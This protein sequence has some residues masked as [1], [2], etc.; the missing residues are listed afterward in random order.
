[1][2]MTR[3][4]IR[5]FNRWLVCGL[6]LFLISLCQGKSHQQLHHPYSD[7]KK[8]QAFISSMSGRFGYTAESLDRIFAQVYRNDNILKKISRPAEK[9]TPWYRYR[10]IFLDTGRIQNGVAFYRAHQRILQQAYERY[11]VPPLIIVAIIGVESRYGRIMGSDK[12]IEALSTMAFDYPQRERFFTEE[13]RAFLQMTAKAQLE[14]LEL[15]G[16]YAGAMGMAQFMPSSY[17]RYAVDGDGDGKADLWHCF[18]DVI[19]SVAN[20]LASHGWQRD[21]LIVDEA[22]LR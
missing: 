14:P 13:L 19:M 3:F 8:A 22:I 18:D 16:S 6:G 20:Y 5:R 7:N 12:V 9:T 11:G 21:G 10:Q 4:A 2:N 15:L 1:M 17:L